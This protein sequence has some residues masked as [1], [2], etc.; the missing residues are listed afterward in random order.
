MQPY[1]QGDPPSAIEETADLQAVKARFP[2][3]DV[4]RV[5]GGYQAVPKGTRVIY[6]MYLESV[7]EKLVAAEDASASE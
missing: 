4:R 3:W 2:D 5:F 7:A 1:P 6:A